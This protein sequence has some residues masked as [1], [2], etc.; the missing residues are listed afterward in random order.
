M[1]EKLD[2]NVEEVASA[3]VRCL[4][5]EQHRLHRLRRGEGQRY[6][7]F[8]ARAAAARSGAAWR[9]EDPG[10]GAEQ[11]L[12]LVRTAADNVVSTPARAERTSRTGT[13]RTGSGFGVWGQGLYAT[14]VAI[15]LCSFPNLAA[16]ETS[17]H[18]RRRSPRRHCLF[19]E[20]EVLPQ[21]GT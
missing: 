14:I 8:G 1:E 17:C 3:P 13:S 20:N 15:A 5:I 6:R 12:P 11:C 2:G 16:E 18:A 9:A 21:L 4:Q 7:R 19:S 10:A